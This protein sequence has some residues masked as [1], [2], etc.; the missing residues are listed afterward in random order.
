MTGEV[1]Y[2]GPPACMGAREKEATDPGRDGLLILTGARF[3]LS[4][5]SDIQYHTIIP[6]NFAT[7]L[8]M[9]GPFQAYYSN[10]YSFYCA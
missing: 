4:H 9:R 2:G 5:T 6:E 7:I 1:V 10:P 8:L 3:S